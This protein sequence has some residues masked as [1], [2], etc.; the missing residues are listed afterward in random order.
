MHDDTREADAPTIPI[1]YKLSESPSVG[2]RIIS[3][4]SND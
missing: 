2:V 4:R 3:C 1:M